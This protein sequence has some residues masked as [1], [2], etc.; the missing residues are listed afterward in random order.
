MQ[1]FLLWLERILNI[2]SC[3]YLLKMDIL[4]LKDVKSVADIIHTYSEKVRADSIP[5]V[6][7]NG[8]I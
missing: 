5:L 4:E 3:F 8:E 6:I 1:V 7:D 2:K